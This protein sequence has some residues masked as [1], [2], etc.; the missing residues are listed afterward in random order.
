VEESARARAPDAQG[1][2]AS[3]SGEAGG[4]RRDANA[5]VPDGWGHGKAGLAGERHGASA[6]AEADTH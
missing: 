5:L 2:W 1:P 3:S 6:G 4:K